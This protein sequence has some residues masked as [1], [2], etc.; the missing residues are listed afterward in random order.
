M[1]LRCCGLRAATSPEHICCCDDCVQHEV[2]ENRAEV[3]GE[4]GRRERYYDAGVPARSREKRKVLSRRAVERKL[5]AGFVLRRIV[6]TV[7]A[8]TRE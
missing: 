4:V 6:L 7:E 5:V 8:H 2:Q 1:R 3:A